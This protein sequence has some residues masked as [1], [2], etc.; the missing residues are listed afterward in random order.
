M[1]FLG[2]L[3]GSFSIRLVADKI[4]RKRGLY[5]SIGIGVIS[6][7]LSAASKF[8]SFQAMFEFWISGRKSKCREEKVEFLG[9]HQNT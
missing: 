4:G 7:A 5:V 2:A 6:A 8:V 9:K 1:I 3:A